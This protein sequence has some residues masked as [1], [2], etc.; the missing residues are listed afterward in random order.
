MSFTCSKNNWP[1][2]TLE[3]WRR[4]VWL[5]KRLP[6]TNECPALRW[7]KRSSLDFG[8]FLRLA[9]VSGVW[10]RRDTVIKWGQRDS[11]TP[12]Y[13]TAT[14]HRRIHLVHVVQHGQNVHTR[15]HRDMLYN[16]NVKELKWMSEWGFATQHQVGRTHDKCCGWLRG[17][18]CSCKTGIHTLTW[19]L[20]V[21][22]CVRGWLH[23]WTFRLSLYLTTNA[24]REKQK[25]SELNETHNRVVNWIALGQIENL[26]CSIKFTTR[27][28][29]ENDI[30]TKCTHNRERGR[31]IY[32][33]IFVIGEYRFGSKLAKR[34]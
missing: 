25:Q 23:A 8:D 14:Q 20:N 26:G 1:D 12:K 6:C 28:N 22:E 31:V 16:S 21:K 3:W 13:S 5:V 27:N 19:R 24:G 34:A 30:C 11:S 15:T 2:C 9:L 33:R 17:D 29:K 32:V 7:Q 4:G 18:L 10:M